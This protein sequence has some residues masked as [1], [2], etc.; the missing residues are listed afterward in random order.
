MELAPENVAR[1]ILALWV[2]MRG[3]LTPA[4]QPCFRGCPQW[5]GL[6][7]CGIELKFISLLSSRSEFVGRLIVA[8]PYEFSDE[9]LPCVFIQGLHISSCVG[10]FCV[11]FFGGHI[12]L[13]EVFP[14]QPVGGDCAGPVF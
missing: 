1:S 6:V 8:L 5:V 3:S 9:R 4:S 14:K 10:L 7:N 13:L 2:A 12:S 11:V